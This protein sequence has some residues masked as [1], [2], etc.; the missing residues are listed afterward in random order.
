[1]IEQDGSECLN[2]QKF[3]YIKQFIEVAQD[4]QDKGY[5]H[6]VIKTNIQRKQA[7]DTLKR[8]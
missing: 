1:M 8:R 5:G 4:L 6:T 7:F 2:E 3:K